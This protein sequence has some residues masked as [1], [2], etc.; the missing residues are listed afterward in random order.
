[1]TLKDQ[2][3]RGLS[4][5]KRQRDNDYVTNVAKSVLS[6]ESGEGSACVEQFLAL[7]IDIARRDN[8]EDAEQLG[9]TIVAIVRAE[10]ASA[11]PDRVRTVLS[12][13]EAHLVE[14]HTE[15]I[16]EEAETKM[17]HWPT[18][19]NRLN[20]LSARANHLRA[21]QELDAAVRAEVVKQDVTS[22]AAG[23]KG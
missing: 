21:I 13:P 10:H 12:V 15:G 8:L 22:G 16:A 18:L 6:R 5:T 11:F 20:Y 3:R 23:A 7:A 17:M 9:Y 19:S 2:L 1:L 14:E 4:R